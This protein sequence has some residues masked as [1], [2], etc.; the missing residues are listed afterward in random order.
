MVLKQEINVGDQT[1]L[2]NE[3]QTTTNP[4]KTIENKPTTKISYVQNPLLTF[5][6]HI[7]V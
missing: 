5:I 7:K 3:N 6:N 2:L 4:M 1:K